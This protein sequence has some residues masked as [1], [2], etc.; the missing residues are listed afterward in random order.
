[1]TM[2]LIICVFDVL[3]TSPASI[4]LCCGSSYQPVLHHFTGCLTETKG[5]DCEVLYLMA[6]RP[7]VLSTITVKIMSY[8]HKTL[9]TCLCIGYK[10]KLV[11][12]AGNV[13]L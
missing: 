8:V 4:Q 6:M 1:M 12:M 3:V 13:M 7:L 9:L 10:H 2:N 5:E 11:T